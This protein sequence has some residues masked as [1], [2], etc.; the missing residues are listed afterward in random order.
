MYIVQQQQL[1][2][3]GGLYEEAGEGAEAETNAVEDADALAR[4]QRLVH[5][6]RVVGP[7]VVDHRRRRAARL[8]RGG[9]GGGR[10]GGGGV[11]VGVQLPPLPPGRRPLVVGLAGGSAHLGALLPVDFPDDGDH[12]A[13]ELVVPEAVPLAVLCKWGGFLKR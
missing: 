7:P 12:R 13:E 8:R 5:V 3:V 10:V 9:G 2:G 4:A 1:V 11:V 6:L